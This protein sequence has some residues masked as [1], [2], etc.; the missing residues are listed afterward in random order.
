MRF[1]IVLHKVN[2][3]GTLEALA[4]KPL[5]VPRNDL[6]DIYGTSLGEQV[7][8]SPYKKPVISAVDPLGRIQCSANEKDGTNVHSCSMNLV[9]SADNAKENEL[10][11]QQD[12]IE[13]D[14]TVKNQGET[15][16]IYVRPSRF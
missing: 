12:P 9:H 4:K 16:A 3:Y 8:P 6:Y 10:R 14:L 11:S 7:L 1:T 5:T 2:Y 13:F 15:A